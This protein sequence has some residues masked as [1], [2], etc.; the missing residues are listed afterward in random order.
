MPIT[1]KLTQDFEDDGRFAPPGDGYHTAVL[2]DII[3]FGIQK[4]QYGEK[5]EMLLVWLVDEKNID[6]QPKDVIQFVSKSLFK[7]KDKSAKLRVAVE[8]LL[9]RDLTEQE[10]KSPEFDIEP[11]IGNCA[12][13]LTEGY[14]NAAGKTRTKILSVKKADSNKGVAIPHDF[15]RDYQ[16]PVEDRW[17]ARLGKTVSPAPPAPHRPSG[18]AAAAAVLQPAQPVFAGGTDD[19]IPF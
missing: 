8:A 3:D 11:L 12:K 1:V 18:R 6:G 19:D 10:A 13:L 7:K 9:G 4:S 16:K 15:K 5:P 2:A 17:A 14:E